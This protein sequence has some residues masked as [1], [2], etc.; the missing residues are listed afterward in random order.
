MYIIIIIYNI[1]HLVSGRA[2]EK[3]RR[4]M[5]NC[6]AGHGRAPEWEASDSQGLKA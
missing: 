1:S 6:G 2:E 3:P 5:D 4:T